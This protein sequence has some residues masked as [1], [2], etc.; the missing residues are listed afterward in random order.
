LLEVYRQ[1]GWWLYFQS[2]V[3]IPVSGLVIFHETNNENEIL[4]FLDKGYK[5][6]GFFEVYL[7]ILGNCLLERVDSFDLIIMS[8][9]K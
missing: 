4:A 5:I 9:Q 8:S 6:K 1:M 3:R 2:C 7:L